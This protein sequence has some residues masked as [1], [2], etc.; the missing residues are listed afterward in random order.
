MVL[1]RSLSSRPSRNQSSVYPSDEE[2]FWYKGP[3]INVLTN[4]YWKG[5]GEHQA[6]FD[7]LMLMLPNGEVPFPLEFLRITSSIYY[8]LFQNQWTNS[9]RAKNEHDKGA[10]NSEIKIFLRKCDQFH[11][12]ASVSIWFQKFQL[13][14]NWRNE[15]ALDHQP[16]IQKLAEE[17][18]A[19]LDVVVHHVAHLSFST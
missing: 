2:N 12:P 18:D 15:D 16:E 5:L 7:R 3:D 19:I 17:M 6:E 11:M 1:F 14:S 10:W 9:L 13:V 4:T 8:D